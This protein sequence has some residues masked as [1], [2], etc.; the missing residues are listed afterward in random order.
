[1]LTLF[2]GTCQRIGERKGCQVGNNDGAR[3]K[4]IGHGLMPIEC[5]SV[6]L[7]KFDTRRSRF[8]RRCFLFIKVGFLR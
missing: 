3:K 7:G 4:G 2:F 8:G 1:M 6:F 5:L